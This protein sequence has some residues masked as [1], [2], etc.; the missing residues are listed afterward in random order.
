[1]ESAYVNAMDGNAMGYG[2][3]ELD[4]GAEPVEEHKSSENLQKI[5]RKSRCL[6]SHQ[7]ICSHRSDTDAKVTH[8]YA[9]EIRLQAGTDFS[10]VTVPG[11]GITLHKDGIIEAQAFFL[12]DQQA[13]FRLL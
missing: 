4:G 1:L 2:G 11:R 9:A 8:Q 7:V 5:F 3:V 6:W 13:A 12:T 10:P